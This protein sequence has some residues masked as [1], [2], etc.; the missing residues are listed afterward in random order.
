MVPDEDRRSDIRRGHRPPLLT[1]SLYLWDLFL[2]H[3]ILGT[4]IAF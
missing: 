4:S 3:R 1:I 2:L